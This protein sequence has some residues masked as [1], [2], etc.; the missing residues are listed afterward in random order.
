MVKAPLEQHLKLILVSQA[1]IF[2]LGIISKYDV[3]PL[4][5][6]TFDSLTYLLKTSSE[7]QVI[8]KQV[9]EVV[10]V[11]PLILNALKSTIKKETKKE[12]LVQVVPSLMVYFK[13]HPEAVKNPMW[14]HQHQQII[15]LLRQQRQAL[16]ENP[17]KKV[18]DVGDL[19]PIASKSE[20]RQSG[21]RQSIQTLIKLIRSIENYY[22]DNNNPKASGKVESINQGE[23]TTREQLILL[24]NKM[25]ASKYGLRPVVK[26]E[27]LQDE[28]LTQSAV[29][30]QRPFRVST[31]TVH[32]TRLSYNMNPSIKPTPLETSGLSLSQL[33]ASVASEQ[34]SQPMAQIS[35][36]VF[37]ET[38]LGEKPQEAVNRRKNSEK[39]TSTELEKEREKR[40]V[41][42]EETLTELLRA[43]LK[44]PSGSGTHTGDSNLRASLLLSPAILAYWRTKAKG[45]EQKEASMLPSGMSQLVQRTLREQ[46]I[47]EN[48]GARPSPLSSKPHWQRPQ[49][50]MMIRPKA[51]TS[52]QV[53]LNFQMVTEKR[54]V[55]K[56]PEA[57]KTERDSMI[58]VSDQRIDNHY[59]FQTL[60]NR[61][62]AIQSTEALV[63]EVRSQLDQVIQETVKRQVTLMM[64]KESH[65]SV[66][67]APGYIRDL[68]KVQERSQAQAQLPAY[69]EQA[70]AK[71]IEQLSHQVYQKVTEKLSLEK[72]RRGV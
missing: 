72:R 32:S 24:L 59:V 12:L 30:H 11:S 54:H 50:P 69:W 34:A 20:L 42:T 4:S 52:G 71:V 63:R 41:L 5:F 2:A 26:N 3:D 48:N 15:H 44:G 39:Q 68:E 47:S 33:T 31:N 51:E 70:P 18:F 36:L 27:A 57:A 35:P 21:R 14:L 16:N 64:D 8:E 19:L 25:L 62:S 67:T 40:R 53:P 23:H 37:M 29:T 7:P 1:E 49:K 38:W 17:D 10:N 22:M 60:M 61:P 6:W 45:A 13:N 55:K 43:I 56:V 9:K 58:Y 46:L 66:L 65:P 28:A